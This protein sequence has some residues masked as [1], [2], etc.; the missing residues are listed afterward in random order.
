MTAPWG[1]QA[2]P[3]TNR[4]RRNWIALVA[5]AVLLV[6][7]LIAAPGVT[8]FL[9]VL[10]LLF[11]LVV[12]LI[13]RARWARI[14]DRKAAAGVAGAAF[15]LVAVAAAVGGASDSSPSPTADAAAQE[16]PPTGA[17]PELASFVGQACDDGQ[18]VM[19]QDGES[20]YCDATDAG[21]L[22][23]VAAA[24]HEKAEAAAAAQASRTAADQARA[25]A[26]KAAAAQAAALAKEPEAE[27]AVR[28]KAAAKA[29]AEKVANAKKASA[30]AQAQ[31]AKVRKTVQ[32]ESARKAQAA[33][34]AE[35]RAADKAAAARKQDVTQPMVPKKPA[36]TSAYY[37]NCD[38]VR[39]AGADPI[40]VGEPGYSRKLD[41]NGDGVGCE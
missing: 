38:D 40:Q 3:T 11:A 27:E 41:R 25:D 34:D 36:S 14:P 7:L 24:D 35:K 19:T 17:G 28:E 26:E 18:L 39:A 37:Q 30:Q 12:L 9:G 32:Q 13:G 23:W 8:A 20:N 33:Q 15:V 21:A 4:R 29:K 31:K 6:V 22:V 10:V 2:A 16:T 5:A 1:L